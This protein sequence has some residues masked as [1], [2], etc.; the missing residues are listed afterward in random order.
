A[1]MRG[2]GG[3]GVAAM[4]GHAVRLWGTWLDDALIEAVEARRDHP[5]LRMTLDERIT[6]FRSADL[7]SAPLGADLVVHAISA[8]GAVAVMTKAAAHLPDVPILS[9]TK[10]FL[11]SSK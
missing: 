11:P 7:A 6:P 2:R 9:V 10:G 5:R 3:A 4:G 8:D 1:R